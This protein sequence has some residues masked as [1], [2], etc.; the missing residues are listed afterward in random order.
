M[1]LYEFSYTDKLNQTE[2]EVLVRVAKF[3]EPEGDQQG[4]AEGYNFRQCRTVEQLLGG[5][6][7]YHFEVL[8]EYAAG[9]GDRP[10]GD[11]PGGQPLIPGAAAAADGVTSADL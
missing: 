6:R 2:A 8:G 4:W 10:P 9:E 1:K 7:R 3:L 11:L 5:E